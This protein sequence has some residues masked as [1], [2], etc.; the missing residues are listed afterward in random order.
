MTH[1]WLRDVLLRYRYRPEAADAVLAHCDV[2][3]RDPHSD[4]GGGVV[5][6]D[7]PQRWRIVLYT[8]QH[9]AAVH[10]AAHVWWFL[11]QTDAMSAY[12]I[13]MM[14]AQSDLAHRPRWR[15]FREL[16]R[17]YRYGDGV[18]PG[19]WVQAAGRWNHDEIWAGGASYSMGDVTLYPPMARRLYERMFEPREATW[20][21]LV[22]G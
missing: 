13:D 7:G 5:Y 9:E 20:L 10:E 14:I 11:F 6:P 19:M 3:V 8:A 1:S 2:E 12:L 18:W 17:T 22:T 21:P 15:P 4:T 16:M